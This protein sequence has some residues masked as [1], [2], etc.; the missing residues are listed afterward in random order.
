MVG[1]M[2]SVDGEYL[3]KIDISNFEKNDVKIFAKI[4]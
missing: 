2:S 1:K 3:I 4:G